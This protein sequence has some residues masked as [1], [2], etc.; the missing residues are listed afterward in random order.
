MMPDTP[1][2]KKLVIRP[3]YRLLLIDEPEGYRAYLGTLP[4]G[5]EVFRQGDGP[6]DLVHLF[7]QQKA[8]LEDKAPAAIQA[9]KPDGLLWISYPK[10]TSKV[11][12]DLLREV[13]WE[14]VLKFGW[15]AVTQIS[16]DDTWSALRFRPA[17]LYT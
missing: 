13:M 12:S 16:I 17:S 10:K 15:Q 7:V 2:V 11:S 14:V 9:V 1:L 3:H 5:V 6:F 4:E 8:E